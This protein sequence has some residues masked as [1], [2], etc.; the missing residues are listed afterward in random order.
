[1]KGQG[2]EED[3]RHVMPDRIFIQKN[4]HI[5]SGNSFLPLL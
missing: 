1:M 4:K 3:M 2:Y 5:T